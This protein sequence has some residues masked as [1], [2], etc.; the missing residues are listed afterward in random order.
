MN[1]FWLASPK[2]RVYYLGP[3]LDDPLVTH[4]VPDSDGTG[5]AASF[6]INAASL[7]RTLRRVKPAGLNGKG[8]VHSHPSGIPQPSLGD[9]EY[10]RELFS[11]PANAAATQCFMPI[12]CD[13]RVY[14]YVYARGR[15]WH[16]ELILV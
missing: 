7:N 5:T 10:L 2:P 11:L 9:L 4:F 13:R 14:P 1:T 16:A 15:L 8:L 12:I 6:R 3:V